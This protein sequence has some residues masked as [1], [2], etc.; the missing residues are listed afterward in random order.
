M[1][2]FYGYYALVHTRIKETSGRIFHCISTHK[3]HYILILVFASKITCL[4][5]LHT[6]ISTSIHP[7]HHHSHLLSNITSVS[8]VVSKQH[9]QYTTC[10]CTSAIGI[11]PNSDSTLTDSYLVLMEMQN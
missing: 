6:T 5:R 10:I 3:Q 11:L 9:G 8:P 7:S 4:F 2:R 1:T